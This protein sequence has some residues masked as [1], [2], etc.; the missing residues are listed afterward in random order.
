M[1]RIKR[2]EIKAAFDKTAEQESRTWMWFGYLA[3]VGVCLNW[4]GA[5]MV[6]RRCKRCKDSYSENK[7][8]R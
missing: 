6:A 2:I 1:P 3:R 7:N 5:E 8:V 4:S